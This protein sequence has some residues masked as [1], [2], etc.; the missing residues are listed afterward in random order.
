MGR[1]TWQIGKYQYFYHNL[2]HLFLS[3]GG[4]EEKLYCFLFAFLKLVFIQNHSFGFC[5]SQSVDE[6]RILCFYMD[7]SPHDVGKSKF[8]WK[9]VLIMKKILAIALA[10]CMVLSIAAFTSAKAEDLI[11]VGII[12]NDPTE[13]GYRAANVAD[14]EATFSEENGYEAQ[15][16][17]S[18]KNEEQIAQAKK[19][20]ADEVDYLLLSAAATTGWDSVLKEAEEAGVTVILFD[21][22]I[23]ADESL[24]AASVVSDMAKEGQTAV[25]WLAEQKL[26]EYNVIHIQGVMGS[27]AQIGRSGAL[28]TKVEENDN[29][30]IVIQQTGNWS[31]DEAKQIVESVINSGEAFNVIY[32][33]NDNMAQG[34]VAAL[35]A[36]GITHGVEGDVIVMGFDCNKWAL[37]ELLAGNWNYDGQCNPFQASTIADIIAKL[38]AGEEL[39]DKVVILVEQ[40]FDAATITAEDVEAFGI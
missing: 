34:A 38:E 8:F 11:K 31:A 20:I 17:Y 19:F 29:W 21:R 39:E 30:N 24:Y 13:S 15:F 40:G 18:L 26:D 5:P 10:L 23:D 3:I 32:A 25:D 37:E 35:D 16:F 33:E 28:D 22:T 2:F 14:M 9:E 7:R 6:R 27:A 36:A 4:V 1:G 12:N